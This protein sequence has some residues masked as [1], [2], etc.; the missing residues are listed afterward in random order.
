MR[1]SL[2]LL[3]ASVVFLVAA[4]A[5]Y[6]GRGL[7]TGASAEA[8]HAVMG[9]PTATHAGT[10]GESWEY[11][12]GPQGNHTFM[13]RFDRDRR[14]LRVDQVLAFPFFD[15]VVA[16]MTADEVR[17]V[18]GT[19][20]RSTAFPRRKELVWDY[21]WTDSPFDYLRYFHVV[22][23]EAGRVTSTMQTYEYFPSGDGSQN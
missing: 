13:V 11:A 10:S 9:E 21:R 5:S 16:G 7:Q 4:C 14:L 22:F 8:V 12:R 23:D 19:P 1:R 2:T 20:L 6:D 17:R 18:L 15:Q 3:V